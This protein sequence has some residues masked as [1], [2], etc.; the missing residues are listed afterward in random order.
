MVLAIEPLVFIPG[1]MG[2]QNKDMIAVTH[3]G[4]ELLSDYIPTDKLIRIG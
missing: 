1:R 3:N 4:S 2:L